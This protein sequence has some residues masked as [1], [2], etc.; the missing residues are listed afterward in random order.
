MKKKIVIV[1]FLIIS[2]FLFGCEKKK[3]ENVEEEKVEI[4]DL[5][6]DEKTTLLEKVDALYYFDINPAKSFKVSDLTNQEVLLWAVYDTDIINIPFA[7]F[8]K[9]AADYLDFSLEPENILCMTHSNILGASDY[10]YLYNVNDKNFIKNVSHVEH[11]NK[12]YYSFVINSYVNSTYQNGD[13]IVWIN[14]LFT[15]TDLTV[16]SSVNTAIVPSAKRNWYTNYADAKNKTNAFLQGK[17]YDEAKELLDV[18][19]AEGLVTYKYTFKL[20]NGNYVLKS[21]EIEQKKEA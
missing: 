15:D 18:K 1:F 20:K 12:G 9:K 16:Y 17:N 11:S 3:K 4:R 5:T 14:K 13:F 6:E 8:E 2:L 19:D 10:L 7:D 21:Y